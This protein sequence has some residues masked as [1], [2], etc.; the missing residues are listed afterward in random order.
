MNEIDLLLE[1]KNINKFPIIDWEGRG[2][3]PSSEEIINSMNNEVNS[4]IDFLTK[5]LN[6]GEGMSKEPLIEQ[7][8]IWIDDWDSYDF[9]TEE[10][11]FIVEKMCDAMK[12]C[13]VDC[14]S[15]LI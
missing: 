5:K 4:F 6:S 7:I 8:Q 9:D 1:L 3:N 15:I 2:L 10:T 14:Q 13:H 12:I 11:E